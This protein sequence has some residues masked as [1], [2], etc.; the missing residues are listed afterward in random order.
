MGTVGIR[1]PLRFHGSPQL[2]EGLAPFRYADVLGGT[3]VQVT[4]PGKQSTTPLPT[5]IQT[6][7]AGEGFMFVRFDLP[8][9]TPAGIF[10]GEVSLGEARYPIEVE[11]EGRSQLHLSPRRLS[12]TAAP[13]SSILLEMTAA[14]GGNAD[15]DI[16]SVSAFGLFD[17]HG[18]ERSIADA[19]RATDKELSESGDTG[20]QRLNRLVDRLSQ[21]HGGLVRLQ[22]QEGAGPLR[23][24]ELRSIKLMMRMPESIKPGHTYSATWPID[25][26]R[27]AVRVV[28]PATDNG[29]EVK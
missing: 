13:A 28:V 8:S 3:A 6:E 5:N 19:F 2:V 29:K 11:V 20:Q 14:N 17:V 9:A 22:I 24:G 26:L 7:P 10:Q 12:L 15:A 21:E 4:L 27:V 23:P 1:A 18:A 16:P 25:R